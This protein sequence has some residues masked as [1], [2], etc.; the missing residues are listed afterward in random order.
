MWF[1]AHAA[2]ASIDAPP[3][4]PIAHLFED[5]PAVRK[6]VGGKVYRSTSIHVDMGLAKITNQ[7]GGVF[8]ASPNEARLLIAAL[9]AAI[10]E[11]EAATPEER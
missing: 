7:A 5:V 9:Q 8:Y 11:L 3:A 1:D 10:K 2:L 4:D 6:F